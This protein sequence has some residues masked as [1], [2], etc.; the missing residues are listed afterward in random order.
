MDLLHV[1][2]MVLEHFITIILAELT[3]VVCPANGAYL[4]A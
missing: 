2:T 4:S 3:V 1:V